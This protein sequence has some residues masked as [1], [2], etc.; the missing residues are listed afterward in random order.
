M[1]PPLVPPAAALTSAE[2]ARYS[3]QI[4]LPE[5]GVEGQCRLKNSR[6]LVVGAGGLGSPALLYLAAAGVGTLGIVDDDVVE[7]SNLQRQ[8]IHGTSDVGRLKAHSARDSIT[9]LNPWVAV[10]MHPL[11]LSPDN[12]VDLFTRYDLV[13]DGTDNFATR[14]LVNDAAVVSKKPY[15]WGSIQGF[16]GQVSVFWEDAPVSPRGQHRG[17]NYRDLYPRPPAEPAPSCAEGGVLGLLCASVAAIMG[18]E[19]IKLI[20]GIGEP[21]LGRLMIYDA[22]GMT[23]RTIDIRKD[24][25]AA[26]ISEPVDYGTQFGVD[27]SSGSDGG[28]TPRELRGLLDADMPVALIDVREPVEWEINRIDGAVLIPASV[29]TT[30]AGR[31]RIPPGAIPVLYCKT[32]A[33]SAE[34][35]ATLLSAGFTET[36]HLQGGI[37]AWATQ[38]DPDMAMY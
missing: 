13:I 18:T 38:F 32:G 25:Q 3:R 2:L 28:I 4:L 34:A 14:Y 24:P 8:I 11:R 17:I 35:R 1:L 33:R 29:L 6:V 20:T 16:A 26:P 10:E 23:Y 36:R 30:D 22:L 15:V 9:E 37:V 19:T 31:A 5:W 27:G 21:L 7:E 12:A